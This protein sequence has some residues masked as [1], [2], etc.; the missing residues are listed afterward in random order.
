MAVRSIQTYNATLSPGLSI[1]RI[2]PIT[3][4]NII[5][6]LTNL[7]KPDLFVIRVVTEENIIKISVKK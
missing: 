7:K 4:A 1:E 6:T 2:P 3:N 5:S